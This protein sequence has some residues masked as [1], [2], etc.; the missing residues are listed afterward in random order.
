MIF[1]KGGIKTGWNGLQSTFEFESSFRIWKSPLFS[2]SEKSKSV[3]SLLLNTPQNRDLLVYLTSSL[4]T[5]SKQDIELFLRLINQLI[6]SSTDEDTLNTVYET[7]FTLY[8][9]FPSDQG[10]QDMLFRIAQHPAVIECHEFHIPFHHRLNQL[11]MDQILNHHSIFSHQFIH[12]F[13]STMTR[14]PSLLHFFSNELAK[15]IM[16]KETREEINSKNIESEHYL[17]ILLLQM[18]E[19]LQTTVSFGVIEEVVYSMILQLLTFSIEETSSGRHIQ[20]SEDNGVKIRCWQALCVLA[21][22]IPSMTNETKNRQIEEL[23]CK[24]ILQL[25]LKDIRFYIELFGIRLVRYS[26][27]LQEKLISLLKEPNQQAQAIP[28]LLIITS[29]SLIQDEAVSSNQL[30]EAA[31]SNQFIEAALPWMLSP[32]G[33]IRT[34]SQF[35]VFEVMRKKQ[36]LEPCYE[37]VLKMLEQ[38]KRIETMRR[39]QQ[40]VIQELND[41]KD[42]SVSVLLKCDV[43]GI[44]DFIPKVMIDS[45]QLVM[46]SILSTWYKEDYPG[47]FIEKPKQEEQTVEEFDNFQRKI[48]PWEESS[49]DNVANRKKQ[50][51][52]VIATLVDKLYCLKLLLNRPNL[53]GLTRTS[54]IFAVKKLVVSSLKVKKEQVFKSVPFV[55]LSHV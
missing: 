17:R 9:D 32:E 49:K 48:L 33:L 5:A 38:N 51:I 2:S 30:T 40:A 29:Y 3:R 23:F 35:L 37:G 31:S 46:N 24:S 25:N 36:P 45:V 10:V 18:I 34:I 41:Y 12:Y 55:G 44:Y 15:L 53:G 20:N 16:F 50:D 54:E 22:S 8:N 47:Y 27:Q 43:N 4:E 39:K 28:S 26:K 52:I 13:V 14:H 42:Y 19:H 1:T 7:I 11:I 6:Q 21:K